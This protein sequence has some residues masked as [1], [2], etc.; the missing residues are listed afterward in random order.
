MPLNCP[1]ELPD[2]AS[3]P[4]SLT[5][6]C[7]EGFTRRYPIPTVCW[8]NLWSTPWIFSLFLPIDNPCPIGWNR[9]RRRPSAFFTVRHCLKNANWGTAIAFQSAPYLTVFLYF[10]KCNKSAACRVFDGIIC[11]CQRRCLRVMVNLPLPASC[12]APHGAGKQRITTL[13]PRYGE[14]IYRVCLPAAAFPTTAADKPKNKTPRPFPQSG[15]RRRASS[16]GRQQRAGPIRRPPG[17][18]ESCR[19]P[20]ARHRNSCYPL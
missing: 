18:T 16:P 3:S 1:K 7:D 17:W 8:S 9:L 15:S 4:S 10:G 12:Y 5:S 14:Q 11:Q 6:L 19:P 20:S 13:S 2:S